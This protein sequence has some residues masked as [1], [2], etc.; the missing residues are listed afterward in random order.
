MYAND[1]WRERLSEYFDGDLDAAERDALEAHLAG[2]TGCRAG[3]DDLR[4]VVEAAARLEDRP[5]ERDLWAGIATRIG[6]NAESGDAAAGPAPAVIDIAAHRAAS[7]RRFSFTLPQLAAAGIVLA[8][9]SGGTVRFAMRRTDPGPVATNPGPP[10]IAAPAGSGP[11][12]VVANPA[13][14]Q[15]DAAVADLE[16]VLARGRD[17]LDPATIRVLEENLAIIDRAIEDA[18]RAVRL[19]PANAYLHNHLADNMKRKLELLRQA[20]AIVRVQS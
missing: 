15:Y 10:A 14:P 16:A 4:A 6:P 20:T 19:D 17:R 2:C 13:G 12:R 5:P 18:R 7:P 3:L 11:V 1:A 8:L 9:F